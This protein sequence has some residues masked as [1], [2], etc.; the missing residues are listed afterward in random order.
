MKHKRI[1][2]VIATVALLSIASVGSVFAE[3]ES[4]INSKGTIVCGGSDGSEGAIFDSADFITLTD[5]IDDV[6]GN[7]NT[8][9][10]QALTVGA[11]WKKELYSVY[12]QGNRGYITFVGTALNDLSYDSHEFTTTLKPVSTVYLPVL[13]SNGGFTTC[14]VEPD[15]RI[16]IRSNISA[17]TRIM[18]YDSYPVQ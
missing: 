16:T 10:S 2:A 8:S 6:N 1:I 7:L 17:G 5:K 9:D 18:I 12:R 14:A 4:K 11:S 3:T 13:L 15:G